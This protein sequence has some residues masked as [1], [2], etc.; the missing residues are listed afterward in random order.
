M[1]KVIY[2]MVLKENS[3]CPEGE[4]LTDKELQ[5]LKLWHPR[6]DWPNTSKVKVYSADVYFC[7]GVRFAT[8]LQETIND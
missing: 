4:L 6:R 3:I 8:V 7:F 2:N 1:R 5:K